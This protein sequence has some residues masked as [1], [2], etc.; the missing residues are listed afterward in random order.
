M[1]IVEVYR[2][3]DGKAEEGARVSIYWGMLGQ[4]SAEDH[5][6]AQ[7]RAYIDMNLDSGAKITINNSQVYDGELQ[8]RMVFHI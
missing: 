8:P 7:G 2:R 5:T 1:V 6:D 3:K 4:R